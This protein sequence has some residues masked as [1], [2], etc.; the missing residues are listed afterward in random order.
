MND[1]ES[2]TFHLEEALIDCHMLNSMHEKARETVGADI[3]RPKK[4]RN[5]IAGKPTKSTFFA[6]AVNNRPY[7]TGAA[8]VH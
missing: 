8:C 2:K 3:I 5:T 4:Q 6:R 1:Y 7:N